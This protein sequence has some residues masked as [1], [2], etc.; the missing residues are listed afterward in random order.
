MKEFSNMVVSGNNT[1]SSYYGGNISKARSE[2]DK[3]I[4]QLDNINK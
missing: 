1:F 3:Y 2:L 4:D